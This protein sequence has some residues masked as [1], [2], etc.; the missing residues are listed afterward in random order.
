MDTHRLRI[1][2]QGV[3]TD[4]F[5]PGAHRPM[6]LPI[7]ER[8]W[9]RAASSAKQ[10]VFLS[11]FK[12]EERKA[13]SALLKAFI[14]EF[15]ALDSVSLVLLTKP[16]HSSDDFATQ[17]RSWAANHSV[18]DGERAVEDYPRVYVETAHIPQDE[19]PAVYLGA[20]VFVLPSRGEGWGRP[21]MEAMAMGRP[22]IAT[23]WSG[24]T[25]F[26]SEH[27]GYPLPIS[28]LVPVADGPFAGHMWAEPSV[29]HLRSIMRHVYTHPKEAS[30]KGRAARKHIAAHYSLQRI[31]KLVVKEL[32]RIEER[33]SP[34]RIAS[35]KE[36]L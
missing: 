16:Y 9:G 22:V 36:E 11:I 31:A 18:I 13:W 19:L 27:V 15:S 30:H 8:V 32:W 14:Q 10:F 21:H 28:G 1:V 17:M 7:G 23:N 26:L 25:A 33:L 34:Q 20:D 6:K 4:F 12:W 29:A 5:D 2:P 24:P 35:G 3:D